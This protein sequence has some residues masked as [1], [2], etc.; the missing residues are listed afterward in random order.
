MK[1][2]LLLILPLLFI[3]SCEDDQDDGET[4]PFVGIWDVTFIG[5]Y[6]N[7]DCTGD[8]D[9]TAW[10]F[11]QAFGMEASLSIDGDGTYEMSVSI[12][13]YTETES[14]T[15]SENSDGT[16]L[17]ID[18]ES[19]DVSSDGTTLELLN[20]EDAHCVDYYTYEV[21]S[22]TDSTSCAEAGNDWM[23]ASCDLTVFTKQ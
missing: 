19:V 9:S 22:H 1:K 5:E 2:L 6:E 15:W 11:A 3:M 18:G 17:T 14:G 12:M 20:M 4:S 16:T 23:E 21:T 7:A 10:A 8:L 13:G